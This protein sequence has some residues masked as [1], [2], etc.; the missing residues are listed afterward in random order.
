M[1]QCRA[2][3]QSTGVALLSEL[4]CHPHRDVNDTSDGWVA[5][6]VF[7]HLEGGSIEDPSSEDRFR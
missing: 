3:L 4:Q 5:D 1:L 2:C 6:T 7:G